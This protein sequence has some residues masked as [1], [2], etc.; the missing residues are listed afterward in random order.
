[1]NVHREYS[2]HFLIQ[3]AQ[4]L[5]WFIIILSGPIRKSSALYFEFASL[6]GCLYVSCS[7]CSFLGV[8]FA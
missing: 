1:M 2:Q 4:Y 6:L 7:D 8:I 3:P 5:E